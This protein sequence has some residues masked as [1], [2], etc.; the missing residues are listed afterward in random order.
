MQSTST[1]QLHQNVDHLADQASST[2]N[3][4]IAATQRTANDVIDK[5]H[6]KVD[7]MRDSANGAF[8]RAASQVDEVA[9]RG[10]ER[11]LQVSADAR[12]QLNRAT[13]RSV[14]YI[15]D[16]PVKSVLIALAAGAALATVL[17]ALRRPAHLRG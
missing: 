16:Q 2:A 4:A 13:E 7:G 10:V 9:R 17:G 15:Q 11:A 1:N 12:Q 6:D 14:V 3:Q 5:V 8:V